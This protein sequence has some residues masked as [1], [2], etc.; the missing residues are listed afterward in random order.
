[1]VIVDTSVL[2][3]Y[4][5]NRPTWQTSWLDGQISRQRV[6]ITSMV[7]SEVLQG[8]RG[9]DTFEAVVSALSEFVLFESVDSDLAIASARNYRKLRE[10]GITIRSLV[11]T[12]TATFCIEGDHE[13]LHN[14]RDFEHFHTHFG[15][16]VVSQ[17][18][19]A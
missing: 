19:N 4:F 15:L 13:L 12:V 1:M 16:K 18:T 6:G 3:D 10:K 7:L 8:V 2:I 14:D 5:G 11:D 17:N 9:D